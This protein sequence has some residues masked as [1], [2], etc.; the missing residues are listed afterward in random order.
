MTL[1]KLVEVYRYFLKYMY[2]STELHNI[3]CQEIIL[4]N[5][6]TISVKFYDNF[7]KIE[8]MCS[9]PFLVS[10]VIKNDKIEIYNTM[11]LPTVLCSCET[12]SLS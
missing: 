11:I 12:W 2:K 1:C 6:Y 8:P 9:E 10:S 5:V 4:K 7:S 3:L